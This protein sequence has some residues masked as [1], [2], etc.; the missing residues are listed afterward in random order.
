[1]KVDGRQHVAW[2][3]P[4]SNQTNPLIWGVNSW[5]MFQARLGQVRVEGNG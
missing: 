5:N 1:M 3:T 2:I 4:A